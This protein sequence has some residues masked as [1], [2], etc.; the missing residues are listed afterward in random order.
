MALACLMF[1]EKGLKALA[2]K[3]SHG[4][5][6]LSRQAMGRIPGLHMGLRR[7]IFCLQPGKHVEALS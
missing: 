2:A 1:S 7:P 5:G 6:F 3:V 4:R